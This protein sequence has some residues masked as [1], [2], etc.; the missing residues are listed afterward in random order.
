MERADREFR[1]AEV[2]RARRE[3]LESAKKFREEEER[4]QRWVV[5]CFAHAR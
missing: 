2:I 4:E 1:R 5:P 3:R